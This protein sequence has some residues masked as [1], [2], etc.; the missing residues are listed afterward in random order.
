[1]GGVGKQTSILYCTWKRTNPLIVTTVYASSVLWEF[2][3]GL[4]PGPFVKHTGF[5][6]GILTATIKTFRA[7]RENKALLAAGQTGQAFSKHPSGLRCS[8][9]E[10]YWKQN[11]YN[12]GQAWKGLPLDVHR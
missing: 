4:R 11:K 3:R 10:W 2:R 7:S 6:T 5:P 8:S 1:M 12:S 9:C